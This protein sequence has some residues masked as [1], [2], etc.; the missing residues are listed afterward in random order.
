MGRPG[1]PECSRAPTKHTRSPPYPTNGNIASS[2]DAMSCDEQERLDAS[3]IDQMKKLMNHLDGRLQ[4]DRAQLQQEQGLANQ[5]LAGQLILM[6]QESNAIRSESLVLR[7][8]LQQT[9]VYLNDQQQMIRS[10]L[11]Q[12]HPQNR[13]RK[14]DESDPQMADVQ[15]QP[16]INSMRQE[17]RTEIHL[18]SQATSIPPPCPGIL[19]ICATG[20]ESNWDFRARNPDSDST[21]KFIFD[22]A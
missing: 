5:T 18:S 15:P 16:R 7:Q 1:S 14:R 2:H 13:M 11:D 4:T 19:V 21:W 22:L 6:Q 9:L 10:E 12:L 8:D 3:V 20:N 17:C